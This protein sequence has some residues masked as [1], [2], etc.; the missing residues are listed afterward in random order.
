MSSQK[1][2]IAYHLNMVLYVIKNIQYCQ[3]LKNVTL[4]HHKYTILPST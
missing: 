3:A 1:Y 4:R 2:N